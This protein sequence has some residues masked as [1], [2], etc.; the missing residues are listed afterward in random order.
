MVA[1]SVLSLRTAQETHQ[2]GHIT[3]RDRIAPLVSRGQQKSAGHQRKSLTRRF[4]LRGCSRQLSAWRPVTLKATNQKQAIFS[5]RP[6]QGRSMPRLPDLP[7]GASRVALPDHLA[8]VR[9]R[10]REP[11]GFA[12]RAASRKLAETRR[13][14]K[15]KSGDSIPISNF[16]RALLVDRNATRGDDLADKADAQWTQP[17]Y[18]GTTTDGTP[19]IPRPARSAR[20]RRR[21]GHESW[22][23]C[24]G[25]MCPRDGVDVVVTSPTPY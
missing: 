22:T 18:T 16:M 3:T 6:W 15:V 20:H 19:T 12:A 21:A 14:R 10:Y 11:H 7:Q 9:A 8:R 1:F 17:F 23:T 13:S 24:R 25:S 2:L 4:L 5:P